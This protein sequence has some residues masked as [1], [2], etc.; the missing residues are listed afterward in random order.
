VWNY[1]CEFTI[2]KNNISKTSECQNQILGCTVR[3]EKKG[4]KTITNQ[5]L[6]LSNAKYSVELKIRSDRL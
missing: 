3:K 1:F 4:K 6:P 5:T 2:L